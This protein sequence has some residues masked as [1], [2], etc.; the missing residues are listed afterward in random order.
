M[1]R[2][3]MARSMLKHNSQL[4]CLT[5]FLSVR[6]KSIADNHGPS[7]ADVVTN[8]VRERGMARINA[9]NMAWIVPL[10]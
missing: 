7:T 3:T 8:D 10:R 4:E 2:R 5:A 6:K 9:V 1:N